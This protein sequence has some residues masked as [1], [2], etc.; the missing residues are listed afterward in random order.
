MHDLIKMLFQIYH[1]RYFVNINRYYCYLLI[2]N[3]LAERRTLFNNIHE[4]D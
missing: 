4:L 1:Y 2:I 3:G